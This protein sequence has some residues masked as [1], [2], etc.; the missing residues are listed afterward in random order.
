MTYHTLL[1]TTR[2]TLILIVLVHRGNPD[3]TV[4][5]REENSRTSCGPGPG[6]QGSS[7]FAP[8]VHTRRALRRRLM[9]D[10]GGAGFVGNTGS[11]G[12]TLQLQYTEHC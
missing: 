7:M 2:R 1:S 6:G 11:L 4:Q 5:I 12:E 8:P 10:G 3:T 9:R